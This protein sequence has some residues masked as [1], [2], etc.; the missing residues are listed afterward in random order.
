MTPSVPPKDIAGQP[1]ASHPVPSGKPHYIRWILL[2]LVLG[3][4]VWAATSNNPFAQ[5]MQEF[6]GWKHD[7]PILDN[8]FSIAAH[9]FRYYKFS[10]QEGSVNVSIVGQF[11]VT[12]AAN[13]AQG[14]NDQSDLDRDEIEI[15]VLGESAFADWR[16]GSAP[17][18][19]YASGKATQSTFQAVLPTGAG[20]Y[21]LIFNNR[22]SPNT[23]KGVQ[24]SAWLR[25]KSWVPDWLRHTKTPATARPQHR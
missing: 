4:V 10:V 8:S 5:G 23:A 17:A 11:T 6:A 15:Y 25:R 2:A 12:P 16:K 14:G 21:Y 24:A 9:S 13:A 19:V 1:I 7:E 20:T 22:F 18:P 3:V